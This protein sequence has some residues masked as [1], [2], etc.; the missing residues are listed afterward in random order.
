MDKYT[1][2]TTEKPLSEDDKRRILTITGEILGL[3]KPINIVYIVKE[4]SNEN[5]IELSTYIS[6]FINELQEGEEE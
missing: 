2:T 1:Y 3:S 4:A 6:Q 5:A